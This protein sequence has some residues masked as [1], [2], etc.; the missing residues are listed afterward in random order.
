MGKIRSLSPG[1]RNSMIGRIFL[2]RYE[3]MRQLGEGGMGAVFLARDNDQREPVVV[4]VMHPHVAASPV[5]RERFQRE[6]DLMARLK[7]P[8]TVTFLDASLDDPEAPCIIMEF[9]PG[10]TLDKLL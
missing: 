7:H 5:F 9:L 8:N 6:V 1:R 10:I 2:S 4:K 3:T